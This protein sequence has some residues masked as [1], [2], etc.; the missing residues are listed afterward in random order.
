MQG[1]GYTFRVWLSGIL[2]TPVIYS[3]ILLFLSGFQ[4]PSSVGLIIISYV[5]PYTLL[6]SVWIALGILGTIALIGN[7]R[8]IKLYLS[9]TTIVMTF[10][11]LAMIHHISA[12][13]SYNGNYLLA[14]AYAISSVIFIWIYGLKLSVPQINILKTVKYSLIYGLTVWL[15]TF[16]FSVPVRILT[17]LITKSFEPISMVKTGLDILGRYNIQ[18]NLS[19]SYFITLFLISLIVINM[20]I[21]EYK[22]KA[23]TLLLAFPLSFP[24]FFYYLLFSG[25]I[26]S[27]PLFDLFTLIAPSLI[28]SVL[29]I[30][31]IDIIP[32]ARV[33]N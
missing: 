29:S 30:W 22:K 21:T 7:S 28:V 14:L 11:G 20:G 10:A 5:I 26:Y 6:I 2:L 12:L 25:E 23:I 18:L 24:V 31:L 15:F 1:I 17:W 27:Y 32:V 4:V 9:V 33:K 16:L 13:M 19:I 8:S 3:L